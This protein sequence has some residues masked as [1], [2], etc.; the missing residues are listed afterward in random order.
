MLFCFKYFR[1]I[2]HKLIKEAFWI[3]QDFASFIRILPSIS[4]RVFLFN[5]K[6]SCLVRGSYYS[7]KSD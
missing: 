7:H 5:L 6:H 2:T 3:R 1:C 4:L